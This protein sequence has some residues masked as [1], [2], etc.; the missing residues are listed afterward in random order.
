MAKTKDTVKEVCS[1]CNSCKLQ[2]HDAKKYGKIPAKVDV[3]DTPWKKLCIDLVGPYKLGKFDPKHKDYK[4]RIELWCLTMIDPATGWFDVV[5]IDDTKADN[6]ANL[7]EIHWLTWFPKP[8]E[9]ILDRGKEF[10]VKKSRSCGMNTAFNAN[11]SP[12][13]IH[14]P[15]QLL[16]ACTKPYTK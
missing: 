4:Y 3:E 8:D 10:W 2:K 16:S 14:K 5:R 11:Q 9:V 12:P 15:T 6:I 1:R 7:L 13:E